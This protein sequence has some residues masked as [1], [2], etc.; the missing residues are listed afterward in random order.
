MSSEQIPITSDTDDTKN[1]NN[2][3][4]GVV[5]QE[6]TNMDNG[7][8][9]HDGSL[10]KAPSVDELL[11]GITTFLENMKMTGGNAEVIETE[12]EKVSKLFNVSSLEDLLNHLEENSNQ[13]KVNPFE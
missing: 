12:R 6:Q 2:L 9:S 7:N 1:V 10:D 4:M 11:Q 8:E 3:E 5:N 13:P